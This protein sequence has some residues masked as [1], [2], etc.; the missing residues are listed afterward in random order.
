MNF[1]RQV[2][3]KQSAGLLHDYKRRPAF[4]VQPCSTWYAC[5][6]K[7][8]KCRV[9]WLNFLSTVHMAAAANT[10]TRNSVH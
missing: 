1:S 4:N 8:K 9:T 2:F 6:G 5:V 7:Y 10:P 3:L